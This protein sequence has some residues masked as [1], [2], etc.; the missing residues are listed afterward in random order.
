MLLAEPAISTK[1]ASCFLTSRCV[2]SFDGNRS[3]RANET[4]YCRSAIQIGEINIA[5]PPGCGKT[6]AA[7]ILAKELTLDSLA[8]APQGVPRIEVTF[9]IDTNGIL[10]VTA[11]DKATGRLQ[12][13]TVTNDKGRLSQEEIDAMMSRFKDQ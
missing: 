10:H 1:F 4:K 12:Q 7:R 2:S 6:S 3:N 13:I 11:Q 9:D 8:P 5:R